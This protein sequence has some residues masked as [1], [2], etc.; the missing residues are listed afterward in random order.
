MIE[1]GKIRVYA[2]TVEESALDQLKVLDE[3]GLFKDSMVRIMPDVHAG[4]GCVIGFTATIT[5]KVIPNLVGVDIGC[6]MQVVELTNFIPEGKEHRVFRDID[7]AIQDNC[8]RPY[9]L[10]NTMFKYQ[11]PDVIKKSR[12]IVTSLRCYDKLNYTG[13]IID[14]IG[15]LGG[16]NHFIELDR[17]ENGNLFLV[18]HSGSRNLGYQVCK[19]YQSLGSLHANGTVDYENERNRIIKELTDQ[20]KTKLIQGELDKLKDRRDEF[21]VNIPSGLEYLEGQ[22]M[23]DYLHD[24]GLVQQWAEL[25]RSVMANC[26]LRE[27]DAKEHIIDSWSCVH[28]YIDLSANI[29]RKGACSAK[30]GEKVIIPLNMKDGCIIAEG[31]GNPDWNYSAPHGAGR[32]MSRT[33]ADNTLRYSDTVADMEGIHWQNNLD[34]LDESPRAYKPKEAILKEI[35]ETVTVTEIIRPIYNFKTNE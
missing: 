10:A 28:N 2:D 35:T 24:M 21:V 29:L 34:S 5:D 19:Y 31:K 14:S 11:N 33:K 9:I 13:K 3:S 25:N 12:E 16:G 23:E 8:I 7:L 15:T 6:G 17:A 18:I 26:I 22:D 30:K 27:I 4:K 32:L 1:V 20:G